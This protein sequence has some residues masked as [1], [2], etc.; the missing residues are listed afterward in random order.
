MWGSTRGGWLF[1]NWNESSKFKK[2]NSHWPDGHPDNGN[3]DLACG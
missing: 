2:S 3:P 1:C